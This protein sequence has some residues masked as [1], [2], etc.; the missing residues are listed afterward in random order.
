MAKVIHAPEELK[1]NKMSIFLAGTIGLKSESPDWQKAVAKEFDKFDVVFLN[2]RRPDWDENFGSDEVVEQVKWELDAMDKA[3]IIWVN[4]LED[5][6]SPI[7]IA[8]TYRHAGSGKLFAACPKGFYRY[9]NVK[10]V[11]E[12]YKSPLYDSWDELKE[13]FE[14]NMDSLIEAWG[15]T[16]EG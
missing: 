1:M 7:T 2:P 5:S 10:A 13:G 14:K 6:E 8:E 9:D 12:H 4:I 11:C 15:F 3:D 16:S